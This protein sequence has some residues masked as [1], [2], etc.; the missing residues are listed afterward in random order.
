MTEKQII[1]TK[2]SLIQKLKEI[3]EMGWIPNARHKNHG[4]V[5]NTLED[6]LGIKE[7]NLPIPNAAE[8]ELKTQRLGSSSLCT[9][10]HIEPSPR[11]IGFVSRVLLPKYGWAHKESGKKYDTGEMSFRQTIHGLARSDRG[12]MVKIDREEKKVLISFDES[13]VDVRHA[14]WLK[15]V[16]E[17]AGLGELDPQP[18]WGFDDL[19]HK[20]GTK[21]LNS[22][23]VQAE[24]KKVKGKEFYKYTK[25]TMLQKFNFEGF[26]R[27][28]EEAKV[29]VD[30]DART[31]HNHGTKFRM[32]QDALPM[33]Y[34]KITTII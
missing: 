14:P 29:L 13:T 24:V 4:G 31:G 26:L 2:Q 28:L 10:V 32:R 17:R 18:Y 11:A 3:A 16:K 34:D 7:N 8:W 33:L 5:G 12:F 1:Y 23:Y 21:L 27:G 19:E 20:L 15:S 25:V 30:F 6:L 22:F 9:L